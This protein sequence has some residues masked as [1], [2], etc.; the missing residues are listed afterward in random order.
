MFTR[1]QSTVP[2]TTQWPGYNYCF[3]YL[4][5]KRD[6]GFFIVEKKIYD[7]ILIGSGLAGASYLIARSKYMTKRENLLVIGGQNHNAEPLENVSFVQ[8]ASPKL[9]DPQFQNA[10]R[11]F[12]SEYALELNNFN[13][14]S[15]LT[16]GG[17]GNFWGANIAEFNLH[18]FGLPQEQFNDLCL[19]YKE[20]SA[21]FD[22]SGVNSCLNPNTKF[23][24]KHKIDAQIEKLIFSQKFPS[25][26]HSSLAVN[27]SNNNRK[28]TYDYGQKSILNRNNPSILSVKHFGLEDLPKGTKLAKHEFVLFIN[29]KKDFFEVETKDLKTKVQQ[30]Y[31]TKNL[32]LA[33]GTIGSTLLAAPLLTGSKKVFPILHNPAFMY[34]TPTFN[35]KAQNTSEFIRLSNAEVRFDVEAIGEIFGAIYPLKLVSHTNLRGRVPFGNLI[36][37][38]L[39]DFLKSQFAILTLY[40]DGRWSQTNLDAS[41]PEPK[42]VSNTDAQ[43]SYLLSHFR[44]LLIPNLPTAFPFSL[45]PVE[46]GSDSH[47]A[48]SLPFERRNLPGTTDLYGNLRGCDGNVKIIDGS[49]LAKL[50]SK[51]CTYTIMA[52]A[53]R[54]A[55]HD[56]QTA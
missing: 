1:L 54:I 36:P 8:N 30:K 25:I 15:T 17:S 37:E 40:F 19:A 38:A 2:T 22:F 27:T 7:K 5:S 16:H 56:Y 4:C 52:N 29:K 48:G 45:R 10:N 46:N 39:L 49:V 35:L 26:F 53:Y 14:T 51:P 28:P 18:E 33:A 32:V 34:A 50:P 9:D 47:Y 43:L 20:L 55:K 21:L 24:S 41:Q 12:T 6:C 23:K 44:K 3:D 42:L 31:Q 11:A 13:L